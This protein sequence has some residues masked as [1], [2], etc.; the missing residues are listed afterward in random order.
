LSRADRAQ[1][2]AGGGIENKAVHGAMQEIAGGVENGIRFAI[3]SPLHVHAVVQISVT[4]TFK[5]KNDGG[6]WVLAIF[7]RANQIIDFI[8]LLRSTNEF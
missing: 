4:V 5:I 1:T 6:E 8:Q 2:L 7:D 3:Q